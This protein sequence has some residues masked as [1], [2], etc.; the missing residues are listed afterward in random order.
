MSDYL[1]TVYRNIAMNLLH[2]RRMS[3]LDQA[4]FARKCGLSRFQYLRVE[5]ARENMTL[6]ALLKVCETFNLDL[7]DLLKDPFNETLR[8][9]RREKVTQQNPSQDIPQRQVHFPD[10]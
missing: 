7:A 3:R 4:E 9:E 5:G 1:R 6:K 10:Q 2:V 8:M